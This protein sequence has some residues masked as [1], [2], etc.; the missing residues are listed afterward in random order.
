M[1]FKKF[2]SDREKNVNLSKYLI[3]WDDSPSKEQKILQNFLYPFW[4]NKIVLSEFRIPGSLFRVDIINISDR[5]AIEYSPSSSHD[6]NPFFHKSRIEYIQRVKADIDKI[7]WLT[8]NNFKV[9]EI[10]KEDLDFL[11]KKYFLD[12]FGILL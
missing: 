8:S 4:K 3:N 7:Q 5:I 12:H 11:S 10:N 6:Y 9:I 1:L 2:N